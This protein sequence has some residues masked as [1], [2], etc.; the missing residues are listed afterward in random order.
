MKKIL[1]SLITLLFISCSEELPEVFTLTI[2]SNPTEGG[3]ITPSS[4]EYEEGTMVTLKANTNTHY[5]FDKWSGSSNSSEST[6]TITMN[7]NKNIIG[8]FKLMDSDG[9]GVT[10]DIDICPDTPSG[11]PVDNT[12]CVGNPLYLDDNGLTIKSYE[13]GR[14]GDTGVING[15]T[16]TIVSFQELQSLINNEGDITKVCTSKIT[17]TYHLFRDSNLNSNISNWDVSNVT[18]MGGMFMDSQFNGDISNWNVSNVT[19]M[20]GMFSGSQFNGDISNWN[21]SNVSDMIEMFSGDSQFNGDISNWDVSNV[22]NM[23]WM[24]LYN[25]VFNQDLS[26][27]VVT[28][29]NLCTN[30]SLDTPQ[31]T[32]PK[33]NFTNCD[34]N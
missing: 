7:S 6:L 31:W 16:Y 29:V 22:T 14:I 11:T 26:N 15:V 12:G 1:F 28:N 3:T 23:K 19:N 32:L 18:N 34:P 13:W 24:F 20:S 9:D 2:T 4:S 33:P 8:N 27:W 21:V 17:Q 30:F 10:D 25:Q 5:E